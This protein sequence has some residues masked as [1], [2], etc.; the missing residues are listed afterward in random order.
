MGHGDPSGC[1]H[2][3]VVLLL[4]LEPVA[5]SSEGPVTEEGLATLVADLLARRSCERC[6]GPLG[7]TTPQKYQ[8][9]PTR[10]LCDDC[11]LDEETAWVE[12]KN[13]AAWQEHQRDLEE[14]GG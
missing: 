12:A 9:D 6:H 8:W 11:E 4:C 2:D 14:D 3:P 10:D 7:R 1:R 13:V 5:G